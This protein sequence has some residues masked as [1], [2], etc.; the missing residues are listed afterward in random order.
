MK[1]PLCGDPESKVV[2]S[3]SV[4]EGIRRRRQCLK[5]RARFT[6]Y[7]RSQPKSFF[8]VKKDGRREEFNHQKLLSGIRKA[9]EKRPLPTGT[10]DKVVDNIES[11]LYQLGKAEILSSIIGDKVMEKLESLDHI[12][13][14][15]FASIYREF[16]NISTLKQAVDTL[17]DNKAKAPPAGQLFLLAPENVLNIEIKKQRLK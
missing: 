17:L 4:G 11:D 7:E 13:Y 1:C 14:I 2:D 6:T 10:I 15:R 8:V 12:A 9:C 16:T 5:C 3:R